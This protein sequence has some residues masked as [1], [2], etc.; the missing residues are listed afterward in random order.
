[1]FIQKNKQKEKKQLL[2]FQCTVHK[3]RRRI[4]DEVALE[5]KTLDLRFIIFVQQ[6]TQQ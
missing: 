5:E 3:L 6:Y 1:M 4:I 2:H